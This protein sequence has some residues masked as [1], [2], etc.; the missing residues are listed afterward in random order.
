MKDINL[1]VW[2]TQLGI[3]VA[4]PLVCFI[5]LAVWLHTSRGWGR[6]VIIAGVLLGV[7]SAV[8]GLRT[9]LRILSN[10]SKPEDE[11]DSSTIS[12]NDHD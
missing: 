12:F 5:L 3:S 8:N 11:D 1:L 9:S 10:A 6:W 4:A 2:L 7:I